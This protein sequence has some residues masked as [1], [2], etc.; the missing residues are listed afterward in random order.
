MLV[1]VAGDRVL[2]VRG[3]RADPFSQGFACFKGLQ[4]PEQHYGKGRLLHSLR[5]LDGRLE[6]AK[7]TDVLHE[8]GLRLAE[9]VS[10][11]GRQSVGF[12]MG[13]QSIFNALGRSMVR[14]FA[15]ALDTPRL[16]YTMTIDQSAKW[17]AE[18]R[19]G[20][21][22]AGP[23]SFD[24]ADVWMLIGSNPL[25]S[26]VAGAGANLFV[27]NHP[28]NTIRAARAR[29]MK[30][31]V[32][33]PRRSETAAFADLFLQPR[34]GKDAELAA[35]ILHVI[36]RENWHDGEFCSSH[37]DGL[38]E[39]RLALRQFAPDQWAQD[40]GIPASDIVRA[41]KMFAL[42]ARTGMVGSGTGPNMARHSNLAEHLI[43]T[44]N[45]VCG[46]FPRAGELVRNSGVLQPQRTFH[47]EVRPL[48]REWETG[49]K[50]RKHGL[51]S[52]RGTMMTAEMVNEILCAGED[53]L[54]AL[55]CVGGNLA[56]AL[57]D[58]HR[59]VQALRALDLLIVIDPRLSATSRLA[60]YVI[61][62]KLQYERPDHTGTPTE[63]MFSVPYAHATPALVPPP[64]GS[65]VVDDWY[66]LWSLAR[67]V[68]AQLRLGSDPIPMDAA[69][70]T[71]DL[72]TRLA[73]GSRVPLADVQAMSGGALFPCADVRVQA[74][75]SDTRFQLLPPDVA[76]EIVILATELTT[77]SAGMSP[78]HFQ[79]TVRRHREMMNS[80]GSDLAATWGR[81]PGNPAYLHPSDI[82]RL[83]LAT[84]DL[85]E[86]RRGDAR[87]GA[88]IA[89]DPG[90]RCGIISM[91]HCWPGL[92]DRPWEATNVLVDAEENVQTINRMPIMT[93]MW[94]EVTRLM[95]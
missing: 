5:R 54:R 62:P 3:D 90:L 10:K 76:Q 9:I 26:M 23:Q 12:F 25:V 44:I 35:S 27:F 70:T 72:L 78:C 93:G 51:G 87:I 1:T 32:I 53:R 18:G 71:E 37:V 84:G 47:A 68:G 16:F 19:L 43:E 61:A 20:S 77:E 73:A 66:A 8:A 95:V 67:S 58:Q 60:H 48:I 85:V 24:D 42:D 64:V 82:E 63:A 55:I 6:E 91:G 17:I 11:H 2:K 34:P 57:P 89:A 4:A 88:R 14:S 79:L 81:L 36:L 15:A 45:V 30:L 21:W 50:T 52:I 92:A 7:S 31:I 39:L 38:D 46:R 33:D 80:T 59:A 22:D 13:T 29:G 83:G 40:I 69:P 41:A 65:D 74:R 56:V 75:R 28:I 86:I 94:V 49:P